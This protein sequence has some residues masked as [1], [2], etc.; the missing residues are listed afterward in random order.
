MSVFEFISESIESVLEEGVRLLRQ[1]D[2]NELTQL[3]FK[4]NKQLIM[5]MEFAKEIIHI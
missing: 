2:V 1:F 5:T 3:R 4:K